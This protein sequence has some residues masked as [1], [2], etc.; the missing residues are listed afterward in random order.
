[1]PAALGGVGTRIMGAAPERIDPEVAVP[2]W[3]KFMRGCVAY[4]ASLDRELK[5]APR[6]IRVVWCGDGA[7]SGFFLNLNVL[8]VFAA[9]L[10]DSLLLGAF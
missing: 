1:V 6:V 5:D 8:A 7:L 2:P 9:F 10:C 3:R 4:R